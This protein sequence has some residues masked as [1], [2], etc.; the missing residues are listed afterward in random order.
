MSFS[1][2]MDVASNYNTQQAQQAQANPQPQGLLQRIIGGAVK[3]ITDVFENPIKAGAALLTGNRQALENAAAAQGK[4]GYRGTLLA[5]AQ[6]P[7]YLINPASG[8][9]FDAAKAGALAAKETGD[10]AAQQAAEKA[11]A[12]VITRRTIGQGAAFGGLGTAAQPGATPGDIIKGALIG[13]A[14]GGVLSKV[15]AGVGRSIAAKTEPTTPEVTVM[16][17]NKEVTPITVPT[18]AEQPIAAP[19]L[20]DAEKGAISRTL[21]PEQLAEDQVTRSKIQFAIA[22][23]DRGSALKYITQL[24]DPAAQDSAMQVLEG[25]AGKIMPAGGNIGTAQPDILAGPKT[26]PRPAAELQTQIEAAHNAGDTATEQKLIA[27]LPDQGMNPNAGLSADEKQALMDQ[28]KVKAGVAPEPTTPPPAKVSSR[29]LINMQ[30]N[31]YTGQ[32]I[33]KFGEQRVSKAVENTISTGA[34]GSVLNKIRNYMLP[35]LSDTEKQIQTK[36]AASKASYQ[37]S[38]LNKL[39]DDTAQKSVGTGLEGEAGASVKNYVNIAKKALQNIAGQSKTLTSAQVNQLKRELGDHI[40]WTKITNPSAADTV[41]TD[42]G[43]DLY[44]AINDTLKANNPDVGKLLDQASTHLDSIK[45]LANAGGQTMAR[46]HMTGI[47]IS[48]HSQAVNSMAEAAQDKVVRFLDRNNG[49]PGLIGRSLGN[50]G[51]VIGKTGAAVANQLPEPVNQAIAAAAPHVVGPI[52]GAT[53]AAVAQPQPAQPPVAQAPQPTDANAQLA[54]QL[55][56]DQA[57]AAKEAESLKAT[58]QRIQD[59]MILDLQQTGGKNLSKLNTLYSI[60]NA[61]EKQAETAANAGNKPLTATAAS[62][63]QS[64]QQAMSGLNAIQAAFNSTHSTG[65]GLFSKILSMKPLG[66]SLPGGQGVQNVNASIQEVLPDIAKALGYGTSKAELSALLDQMPN[67]SDTQKSAQ[68]KLSR[69]AQRIQDF[70]QQ[71]LS[72]EANYVQPNNNNVQDLLSNG[73]SGLDLSGATQ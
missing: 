62:Q 55:T 29:H 60:F 33:N 46:V 18:P 42:V 3:P 58:T 14:A 26:P 50:V 41:A 70:M 49:Q 23:N 54:S 59:A 65:E 35:A 48:Y 21:T 36:L 11:L 71:Y 5:G 53:G 43:H 34:K 51:N 32:N 4:I 73:I 16:S 64:A 24:H 47:P 38:D 45:M 25:D 12:S 9:T 22:S 69:I 10:I 63:V 40:P 20:S 27:Q 15:G 19:A 7:L 6:L 37:V 68:V 72:I 2:L 30:G 67:T 1:D 17:G 8:A 56:P 52:A 28:A 66:V 31:G 57:Q 13:G 39:I 44:T 61:Q